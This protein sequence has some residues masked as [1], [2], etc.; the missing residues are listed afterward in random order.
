M[1]ENIV[2]IKSPADVE[3]NA[4][5][6]S[7]SGTTPFSSGGIAGIIVGSIVGFLFILFL[8]FLVKRKFSTTLD[9][10]FHG[11]P[12]LATNDA[13]SLQENQT[14]SAKASELESGSNAKREIEGCM[15]PGAELGAELEASRNI[16]EMKSNEEV[17]YELA[18]STF[19]VSELPS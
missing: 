6:I 15:C 5:P 19:Q 13:P 18:N 4:K 11:K 2:A 9:T 12:E 7:D 8:A 3:A 14:S 1:Q 16:Q 17:G 10:E